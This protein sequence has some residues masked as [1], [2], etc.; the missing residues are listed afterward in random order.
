VR[1]TG[2]LEQASWSDAGRS[3]TGRRFDS[4]EVDDEISTALTVDSLPSRGTLRPDEPNGR[5]P[6]PPEIDG[7]SPVPGRGRKGR[8]CRGHPRGH[9]RLHRTRADRPPR[10][11]REPADFAAERPDAQRAA[12]QLEATPAQRSSRPARSSGRGLST[13]TATGPIAGSGRHSTAASPGWR[14]TSSIGWATGAARS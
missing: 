6:R 14:R 5:T 11:P 1:L 8:P 12:A 2:T 9:R 13:T 7:S 4:R 10:R 3:P